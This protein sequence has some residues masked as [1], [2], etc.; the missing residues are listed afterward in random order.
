MLAIEGLVLHIHTERNP[1]LNSWIPLGRASG[2]WVN[3]ID[4]GCSHDLSQPGRQPGQ[5][6]PTGFPRT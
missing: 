6:L 2:Q 4:S 1:N 3:M 5:D